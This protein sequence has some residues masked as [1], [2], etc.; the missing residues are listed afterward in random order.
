MKKLIFALLVTMAASQVSAQSV[1]FGPVIGFNSSKLTTNLPDIKE[2][3]KA[4][5]LFGVFLRMGK[6]LYL[7]PELLYTT[8]GGTL[9]TE[10]AGNPETNIKL[11]QMQ[12]PVLVGFRMINIGLANIRIMAGPAAGFITNKDIKASDLIQDPIQADDLKDVMWGMHLGAGVDV[13]FM[14]L[15]VRYEIG[16]NNIYD[17]DGGPGQYDIKNNLWHVSLGFKLL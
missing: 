8:K 15:D 3:A 17:P 11:K 2:E 14:T 13:L 4:N 9:R 12:V 10:D 6:K 16:L 7:Q 5:F 1:T